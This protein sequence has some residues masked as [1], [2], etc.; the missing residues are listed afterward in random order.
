MLLLVLDLCLHRTDSTLSR[1]RSAMAAI[2][3]DVCSFICTYYGRLNPH[4]VLPSRELIHHQGLPLHPNPS[5]INRRRRAR[6]RPLLLKV[7]GQGV[8]ESSMN[9]LANNWKELDGEMY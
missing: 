3:H 8:L 1:R 2:D 4:H 5:R 7:L 9:E 6:K